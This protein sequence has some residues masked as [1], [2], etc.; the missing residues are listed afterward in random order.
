MSVDV[1]EKVIVDWLEEMSLEGRVLEVERTS[2]TR[3]GVVEDR[4][5]VVD[6]R[7]GTVDERLD[8]VDDTTLGAVDEARELASLE[9]DEADAVVLTTEDDSEESA[10]DAKDELDAAE[11]TTAD[12]L[13]AAVDEL[14]AAVDELE[15]SELDTVTDGTTEEGVDDAV[16]D[17]MDETME[18]MLDSSAL[19]VIVLTGTKEELTLS[20]EVMMDDEA[21]V[22]DDNLGVVLGVVEGLLV[23]DEVEVA[24]KP[25]L[26]DVTVTPL[27]VTVVGKVV[28]AVDIVTAVLPATVVVTVGAVH[29]DEKHEHAAD[30]AGTP[31]ATC[32]AEA[33]AAKSSRARSSRMARSSSS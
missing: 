32:A 19:L 24:T 22:V 27:T 25:L 11:L 10:L 26:V 31:R 18:L 23:V 13:A 33:K 30:T 17:R 15:T 9:D 6:E 16:L 29:A 1:G 8:T 14:A 12:E 3:L 21:G 2:D 7:S 20:T 5:G 28:L 4:L